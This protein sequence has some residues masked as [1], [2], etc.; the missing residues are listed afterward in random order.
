MQRICLF[1]TALFCLSPVLVIAD[2]MPIRIRM[3]VAHRG[4]SV[5]QPEST[6]PAYVQAI[7]DGATGAECDV[8]RSAD[9][10][11]FLCHDDTTRKTLA[12]TTNDEKVTSLSYEEIRKR[13]AGA[14][15][16]E[17]FKGIRAPT[18]D[19]YLQVL[20]GSSCHPVIEIKMDG[21]AEQVIDIVKRADMLD[22]AAI[23]AFSEQAVKDVRRIEPKMP[24]AWLYAENLKDKGTPEENADR[25]AAFLIGKSKALDTK[26]LDLGHD[27]LSASLIKKLQAEGIHVWAWT[28]NDPQRMKQLLDWGIESITTDKPDLLTKILE[29]RKHLKVN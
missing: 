10:I 26:M 29:E 6:I 27:I 3:N 4:A 25:L 18:L 1:L 15:K 20:K 19:E 9:G 11:I 13:D 5:K 24:V 22:V 12:G 14:W 28:V 2:E 17:Q 7:V 8:Y 21:I 23:I 16:G